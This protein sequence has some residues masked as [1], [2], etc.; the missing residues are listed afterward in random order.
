M[1]DID[2]QLFDIGYV[3]LRRCSLCKN[4]E[5]FNASTPQSCYCAR[6]RQWTPP[7]FECPFWE[8]PENW[9]EWYAY[10]TAVRHKQSL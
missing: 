3:P 5:K 2:W 7:V 8:V 4:H 10:C 6:L 9:K 1:A